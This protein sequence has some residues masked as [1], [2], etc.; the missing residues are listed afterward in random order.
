V[1]LERALQNLA[2]NAIAATPAGGSVTLFASRGRDALVLGV[3]DTGPG[4]R[5]FEPENAFSRE[6]PQVKD[7]SLR[8]GT[9]LGLYIVARIAEAHGGRAE[10]ENRREG[11]AEVRIVLPLSE[12]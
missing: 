4:F 11:G 8:S 10:A 7:H 5:G 1:F 12:E 9:G 3:R 6:R 2:I